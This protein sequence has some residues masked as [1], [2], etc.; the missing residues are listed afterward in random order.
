MN[1][2]LFIL[3]QST[4]GP[5]LTIV[6]LLLVAAFI[7]YLTAWFYAKSVYTPIIKGLEN[8]K[9]EL[10]RQ[11]SGLKDEISKLNDK[12][13]NLN[14]QISKLEGEIAEKIKEIGEKDKAIQTLKKKVKE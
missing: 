9:A 12:V 1:Q 4:T 8:D 13:E 5:V 3:A 7:G 14:G 11:I 10:N 2:H 6:G